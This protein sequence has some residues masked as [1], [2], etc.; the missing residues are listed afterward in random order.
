[1]VNFIDICQ[2]KL[3]Y[4]LA[5]YR[6]TI[7]LLIPTSSIVTASKHINK[8]RSSNKFTACIPYRR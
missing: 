8:L 4:K 2:V 6:G 1:M 5:M 7:R 3:A